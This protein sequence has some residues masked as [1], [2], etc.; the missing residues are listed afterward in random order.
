MIVL[1]FQYLLLTFSMPRFSLIGSR[2]ALD[3]R[4]AVS[5]TPLLLVL[6]T[7]GSRHPSQVLSCRGAFFSLS[8]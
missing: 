7:L 1:E 3:S 4:V 2:E 6:G 5:K 8:S